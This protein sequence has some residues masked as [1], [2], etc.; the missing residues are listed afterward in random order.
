MGT[1]K[2]LRATRA[3]IVGNY[4]IS[5]GTAKLGWAEVRSCSCIQGSRRGCSSL[6]KDR[7]HR[8]PITLPLDVGTANCSFNEPKGFIWW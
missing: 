4:N 1:G 5:P 7:W 2:S 8:I 3:S 6:T